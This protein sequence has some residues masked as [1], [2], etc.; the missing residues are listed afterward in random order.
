MHYATYAA[1]RRPVYGLSRLLPARQRKAARHAIRRRIE[2]SRAHAADG[3]I[4]SRAKSGRTW[5][6]AMISR[7]YQAHYGLPEQQLLE[8]DNFHKQ[9][10]R[11]PRLLFTHGFYLREQ[12]AAQRRG[13]AADPFD[14]PLIFLARHPCDIA[15]SE[16]F[17]STRRAKAHKKELYGVDDQ[18]SMFEFVMSG[19]LGLPTIVDYFNF[20][21][22]AT[23]DYP[24]F[25][26]LHYETLRADP[27]VQMRRVV[28]FLQAPFTDEAIAEAVDF[29]SFENLKAKERENFFDNSRL[30]PR[31]PDDPDSYKVRRAKVGG[32]RDYFDAEQIEVMEGY[33][34][35][36]LSVDWSDA[37]NYGSP[38]CD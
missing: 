18:A 21:D 28:N 34:R 17:Q 29:A 20:W 6:R 1:L 36:N 38:G 3:V 16:Y 12:F 14:K 31:D 13:T 24:R 22:E 7:L 11:I 9:Q 35:N 19:A 10:P 5:L 8:F 25:L 32:Y 30:A 15:V 37:V 23:R 27:L 2:L 4:L 33:L 26:R